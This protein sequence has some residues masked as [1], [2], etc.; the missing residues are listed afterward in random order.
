MKR[1]YNSRPLKAY[2]VYLPNATGR[3][4][5]EPWPCGIHVGRTA[6][7][8]RAEVVREMSDSAGNLWAELRSRRV[9]GE[10]AQHAIE[11][12]EDRGKYWKD[13]RK[14]ARLQTLA[15]AFND[16]YPVST[17]VRLLC[18]VDSFQPTDTV[19]RT[20]AWC[21]NETQVLVSVEGH[22]GGFCLTQVRPLVDEPCCI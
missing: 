7:Q 14:Y 1:N 5:N 2:E 18:Y 21:P 20:L 16:A 10:V 13:T 6:G 12:Y 3:F 15:D 9:L 8:A 22:A 11:D 17:P 4:Y 19:T